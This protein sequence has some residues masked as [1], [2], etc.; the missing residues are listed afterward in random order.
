MRIVGALTSA[1]KNDFMHALTRV[2]L[3]ALDLSEVTRIDAEGVSS[4]ILPWPSTAFAST[5]APSASA[6]PGNA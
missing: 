4:A 2:G 3:Y 6:W 1:T 5:S